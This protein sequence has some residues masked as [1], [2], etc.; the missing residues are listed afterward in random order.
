MKY[1][2][3]VWV[4]TL[5]S[6]ITMVQV[7]G[8]LKLIFPRII[9]RIT[10][11]E[12]PLAIPSPSLSSSPSTPPSTP[13]SIFPTLYHDP[14][15]SCNNLDACK[16]KHLIFFRFIEGLDDCSC[17]KCSNKYSFTLTCNT[18]IGCSQLA[19]MCADVKFTTTLIAACCSNY[20]LVRSAISI[21]SWQKF[22]AHR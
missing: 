9:D 1:D 14:N 6:F 16:A 2:A 20:T 11:M 13:P 5:L 10:L 4:M 15:A 3:I 19:D 17:D 12:V 8:L 18:C 21:T 7:Q 22:V